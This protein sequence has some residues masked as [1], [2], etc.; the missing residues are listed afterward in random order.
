MRVAAARVEVRAE[1]AK[2]EESAAAR[3]VAVRA[4]VVTVEARAGGRAD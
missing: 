2:V 1:G 4:A 3:V